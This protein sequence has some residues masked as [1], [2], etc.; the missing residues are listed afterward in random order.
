[1]EPAASSPRKA[2][3]APKYSGAVELVVG[4]I[5]NPTSV[6]VDETGGCH[7]G[8]CEPSNVYRV[9]KE[10]GMT[11]ELHESPRADHQGKVAMG[12]SFVVWG[13]WFVPLAEGNIED[14][15]AGEGA[16]FYPIGVAADDR[17][18]FL[19]DFETGRIVTVDLGRGD[20]G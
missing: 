20:G 14:L 18:V 10:G 2:A 4:S 1:M 16:E 19:G 5:F 3:D 7:S 12:S 17:A 13:R 8:P 9:P 11:E 15:A 6:D